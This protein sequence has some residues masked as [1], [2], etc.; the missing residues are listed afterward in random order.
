MRVARLRVRR[1][2]D[3]I[4][5]GDTDRKSAGDR[6][7]RRFRAAIAKTKSGSR[8]EI[9]IPRAQP[10]FNSLLWDEIKDEIEPGLV[11]TVLCAALVLSFSRMLIAQV[12]V[13]GTGALFVAYAYR[14]SLYDLQSISQEIA[15]PAHRALSDLAT[16]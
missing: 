9:S 7:A 1:D 15:G 2:E 13:R 10:L 12:Y 4:R 3:R 6:E 8:I 14:A 5:G 16:P 11:V